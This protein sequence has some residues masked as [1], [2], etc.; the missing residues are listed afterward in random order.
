MSYTGIFTKFETQDGTHPKIL[1]VEGMIEGLKEIGM[2]HLFSGK[3]KVLSVQEKLDKTSYPNK[4]YLHLVEFRTWKDDVYKDSN[5]E[6]CAIG[7]DGGD[8]LFLLLETISKF[9]EPFTCFHAEFDGSFGFPFY[10]PNDRDKPT[11]YILS[12]DNGKV[13]AV[14]RQFQFKSDDIIYSTDEEQ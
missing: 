11:Y 10:Y 8:S 2:E 5:I 14:K 13:T 9:T 1:D 7:Y 6:R 12:C 4:V 3:T